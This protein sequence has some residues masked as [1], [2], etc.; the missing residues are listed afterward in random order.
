IFVPQVVETS[1]LGAV[2]LSMYALGDLRD[3]KETR[4]YVSLREI[5]TPDLAKHKE[6]ARLFDIYQRIYEKLAD[7][8][9]EISEIQRAYQRDPTLT[10]G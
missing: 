6:Y 3:L 10:D 7:E 2:F 5:Y 9:D 4:Q 1:A 8:F